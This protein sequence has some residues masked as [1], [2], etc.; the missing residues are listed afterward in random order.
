LVIVLNWPTLLKKDGDDLFDHYR[1]MLESLGKV[2]S[3][4][5][6]ISSPVEGE[7]LWRK[8]LP[9]EKGLLGLILNKYQNK[10]QDPSKLRRLVRSR[11]CLS[12]SHSFSIT[13][14]LAV[15]IQAS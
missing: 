1:H 2:F 15:T 9:V 7:E 10:F 11:A 3:P 14:L 8:T 13:H 6:L 5:P 12:S 4:S